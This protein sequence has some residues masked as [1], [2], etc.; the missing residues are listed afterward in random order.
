MNALI[1]IQNLAKLGLL[2]LLFL[3]GTKEGFG[4]HL[5]LISSPDQIINYYQFGQSPA[6]FSSKDARFTFL[7]RRQWLGL[8]DY[9]DPQY[10]PS[11][12][13]LQ[14]DMNGV[15]FNDKEEDLNNFHFSLVM[16][17]VGYSFTNSVSLGYSRALKFNDQHIVQVGLR[18]GMIHYGYKI[19]LD[20]DP[21]FPQDPLQNGDG[22]RAFFDAGMS[23][24]YQYS[25][26][27]ELTDGLWE[28][29]ISLGISVPHLSSFNYLEGAE[30]SFLTRDYLQ[31]ITIN[32]HW[33]SRRFL[34]EANLFAMISDFSHY[35]IDILGRKYLQL[36][37]G[38]TPFLA[39]GYQFNL[40]PAVA[41]KSVIH[42]EIG[43]LKNQA[44]K[45]GP[46]EKG[47]TYKFGIN[48]EKSISLLGVGESIELF[49]G[50][51]F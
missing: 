39:L 9:I 23:L 36:S 15:L 14:G 11:T 42:G 35:D 30:A 40:S 33:F 28:E 17:K 50:Y 37:K 48:A 47:K 16:D 31:D 5:P 13:I 45:G 20:E 25:F 43:I 21:L 27:K 6:G 8:Q 29:E 3:L 24:V 51:G 46:F 41:K 2:S 22:R 4:Q 1:N 34:A 38:Y 26:G 7:G 49:L 19:P 10:L 32:A 18:G 12:A 44:Q